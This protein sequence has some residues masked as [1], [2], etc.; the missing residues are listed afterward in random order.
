MVA[1]NVVDFAC[2]LR[3]LHWVAFVAGTVGKLGAKNV[4]HLLEVTTAMEVLFRSRQSS[5]MPN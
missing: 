2:S 5:A 3:F 4:D 1:K